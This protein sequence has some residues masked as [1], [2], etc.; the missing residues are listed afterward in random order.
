M[1]H[2]EKSKKDISIS[3]ILKNQKKIILKIDIE[4][5]EYNILK[6]IKK[7]EKNILCLI[8]E[9]HDIKKNKL[10]I[11]RFIGKSSLLNC[12]ICPN[13]S[14]GFDNQNNP[15]TVEITFI[16]NQLVKKDELNNKIR[17]K[18]VPNNLYKKN[19]KII[20]KKT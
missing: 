14:S 6:D 15:K 1:L 9:F 17:S 8:I 7:F 10:K 18:C 13:N 20:F 5:D 16:N 12:N 19:F 2:K 4:G 11:K 3:R